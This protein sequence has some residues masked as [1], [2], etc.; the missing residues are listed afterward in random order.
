MAKKTCGAKTK[1]GTPCQNSPMKN[2]RCHLHGGKSLGGVDSPTYKHGRYSKV[3]K[4]QLAERFNELEYEPDPM[5]IYPELQ[6]QRALLAQYINKISR[7]KS[8]SIEEARAA[9]TLA[10][11][12]V[13]TAS[14]IVKIRNDTS[15]TIAEVKFLQA[16]MQQIIGKYLPDHTKQNA[17]ISDLKA[18]IPINEN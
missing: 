8:I 10:Q 6:L 18:L 5:D 12:V 2:G 14:M 7:K 15:F 9:S 13:K 3:M 17:F 4:A 1:D 16:G 11:D